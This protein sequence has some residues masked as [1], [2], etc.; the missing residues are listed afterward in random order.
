MLAINMLQ[1]SAQVLNDLHDLSDDIWSEALWIFGAS[2]IV[3][4]AGTPARGLDRC[5]HALLLVQLALGHAV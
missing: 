4:P 3:F 2:S 5:M 1:P